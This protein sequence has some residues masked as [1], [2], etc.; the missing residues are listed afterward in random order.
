MRL[1]VG[2]LVEN[3]P[4]VDMMLSYGLLLEAWRHAV[5]C[6]LPKYQEQLAF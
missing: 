4:V 5:G 2:L 6:C 1:M 3:C